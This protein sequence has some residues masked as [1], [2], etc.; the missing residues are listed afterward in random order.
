V[1]NR[2]M[3]ASSRDITGSEI[4][5]TCWRDLGGPHDTCVF[6]QSDRSMQRAAN[7][8]AP[9]QPLTLRF[10]ARRSIVLCMERV[11]NTIHARPRRYGSTGSAMQ[12][13]WG[14]HRAILAAQLQLFAVHRRLSPGN[15]AVRPADSGRR[16]IVIDGNARGS[17]SSAPAPRVVPPIGVVPAF[18]SIASSAATGQQRR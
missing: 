10:L 18:V 16:R 13:A 3:G 9:M 14:G 15:A 12:G 8:C 1:A 4:S 11:P 7:A 2:R 5:F 6:V 17:R